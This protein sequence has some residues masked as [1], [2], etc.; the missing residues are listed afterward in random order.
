M[1]A[2]YALFSNTLLNSPSQMFSSTPNSIHASVS[3]RSFILVVTGSDMSLAVSITGVLKDP[4]ARHRA[5]VVGSCHRRW[6]H[7][8]V[9]ASSPWNVLGILLLKQQSR[10]S[11][12]F[13]DTS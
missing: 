11:E 4:K 9:Q 6:G 1:S 8:S 12:R 2:N 3:L 7:A 10:L 5:V 13:V